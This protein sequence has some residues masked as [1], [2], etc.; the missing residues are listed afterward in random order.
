LD[1]GDHL[2]RLCLDR[3]IP[4]RAIVFTGHQFGEWCGG[5][6]FGERDPNRDKVRATALLLGL[7]DRLLEAYV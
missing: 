3:H 6:V 5:L 4:R 1:V 7:L 2:A